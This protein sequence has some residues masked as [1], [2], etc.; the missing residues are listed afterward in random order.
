[1]K[2][3]IDMTRLIPKKKDVYHG[4]GYYIYQIINNIMKTPDVDLYIMWPDGYTPIIDADI[5]LFGDPNIHNIFTADKWD[6]D[7][8]CLNVLFFPLIDPYDFPK[9]KKVKEK[10]SLLRIVTT[11]HDLR[12][13]ETCIFDPYNKYYFKYGMIEYLLHLLNR[14]LKLVKYKIGLKYASK[15]TDLIMTVSNFSMQQ[16]LKYSKGIIINYFYQ[17]VEEYTLKKENKGQE[18]ILFVSANREEK[19]FVR[20]AEAY[21]KALKDSKINIPLVVTGSKE[22]IKNIIKRN[23]RIDIDLFNKNVKLL[24]YVDENEMQ[25]LYAQCAF[26]LYTSKSEGFGLPA[27]NAGIYGRPVVASNRTSIPEVLGPM[28][29]YVDPYDVNSIENGIRTMSD[30]NVRNLY[31]LNLKKYKPILK[32]LIELNSKRVIES[33]L[34][35]ETK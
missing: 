9:L 20:A 35:S 28:A 31:E 13:I 26:L 11:I 6:H 16:I 5:K 3:C 27:L 7:Y 12:I 14:Q 2:V 1:M 17:G 10:H 32:Q 29:L 34:Y 21:L 33:M 18:F 24:G 30:N 4:G 22:S 8:S 23:K 25:N 19:N 15:S